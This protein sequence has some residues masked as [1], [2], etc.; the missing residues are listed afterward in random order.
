MSLQKSLALL[1]LLSVLA[2][3]AGCSNGNGV[4]NPVPP[5]SGGFSKSNLN[6]TYVF[7]ISGTDQGNG[8]PY[9]IVGTFTANGNGSITGGTLDLNDAAFASN[10]PVINPVA[11]S[12]I[13]GS[14]SYNVGVDGRGQ[15]KLVTNTPFSSPIVLDFVL[16]DSSHGLV[17]EFDGNGSG[18]GTIDLQASGTTASGTYAFSFGGSYGSGFLVTA[19]NFAVSGGTVTGLEDYNS[20]GIPYPDQTLSGT[21]ALGPSNTPSTQFG[22]QNF[23]VTYDV[24]AINA[25]H[26]K[27][28]EMDAN[29]TLT[30]DAFSQT[31]ATIPKGNLA[32][33]MM[34]GNSTSVVGAGGFMVSDGAGN[35]TN[36]STMDINNT[37]SV[38]PSPIT[39]S[40][41]YAA[42]GT[43]RF[44][45]SGFTAGFGS[46]TQFA[47]YPSSG[48]IFLLEIDAG[49]NLSGAA[50]L[51]ASSIPTLT[52]A[53]GYALNLTGINLA[54]GPE[55]DDIAEFAAAST[56]ATATGV[57]DE[58]YAPGGVPNYGLKL[59]GNFTTPDTSGRGQVAANAGSS[60]NGTLNGGF[61]I[62][63]YAV[64]GTTFPFIETDN[65]QVAAGVFEIQNAS[66]SAAV[67]RPH[68]FVLTPPVAI[69]GALRKRK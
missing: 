52:A 58:N 45:L 33:A 1:S 26:L 40:G 64:D 50:Y 30:G 55:V 4:T 14:S 42:A 49:F 47:A 57:T 9:A 5:P 19:G 2:V 16:Q 65:G 20:G 8:A 51:Q 22:T 35:I 43:G 27:F 32:F 7:S 29:G 53:Q 17:T 38:S 48:G 15:A 67:A 37:G 28:I 23:T 13:S 61:D 46:G 62:T 54:S 63:Y 66:A 6:G 34:G 68:M 60:T 44:T 39:F 12:P 24:Y 56:G 11:N 3:L 31:S 59:A 10:S 69:H 25:A 36:T 18:S 41:Q 21:L